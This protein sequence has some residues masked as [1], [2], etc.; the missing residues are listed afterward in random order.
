MLLPIVA[1]MDGSPESLAAA[2]W[3]AREALHRGLP[4]RLVH[5]WEV[6]PPADDEQPALPELHVPQ[7]WARRVLRTGLDR[8][9]ERYPQV[10]ITAEQVPRPPVP[11][12]IG[13]AQSAEMLVLG[14]QGLGPVSAAFAGSVAGAVVGQVRQPVVLVRAGWTPAEEQL[15]TTDGDLAARRPVVLALD[16]RHDCTELLG[17]AFES[18]RE[19]SAPLTILYAWHLTEG[20]GAGRSRRLDLAQLEADWTLAAVVEPY[21]EKYPT[22]EVRTEAVHD[23]PAHALGQASQE[24]A[25]LIVGRRL[26]HPRVGSHLVRVAHWAIHH[27]HCPVAVVAH[28]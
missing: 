6:T 10:R 8:L 19:R 17:F 11:A 13:A 7:Y 25:L 20:P 3:A 16:V 23:R 28:E 26:R 21:R 24:A 27:V 15:P 1:G 18:A 12:L 5:A 4:L 2:D 14:N 22:V 9:T